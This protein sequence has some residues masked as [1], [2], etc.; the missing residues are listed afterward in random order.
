VRGNLKWIAA[1]ALLAATIGFGP[2]LGWLLMA[3]RPRKV[4]VVDKSVPFQKYR[5]HQNLHWL[6]RAWKV[7]DPS[8]RFLEPERD[9]L[10]FDP[11]ERV[12]RDLR[13]EDLSSADVL[14]VADTYGV[15]RGDYL[16]PGDVAAL[17]RSPKIYGGMT[18]SEA[19]A[20]I[21]FG[22]RGG[23]VVAEFNTFASPTDEA[24]RRRLE[25]FFGLRWTRWVGRYWPNLRDPSEVPSWVGEV[26]E[27]LHQRPF[28]L[29][30]P[31]LVF[32]RDDA[33]MV[34]LQPPH[35][36][37]PS[38]MAMLRTAE[39]DD[40]DGLPERGW[41]RFW[42]DVVEAEG[43]EVVY[44]F[45]V[46]CTPRGRA[47]LQEHGL[48]ARFPA[49]LRHP[50]RSGRHS[51]YLAGDFVDTLTELGDAERWGLLS[52]RRVV[53][54]GTPE[55]RFMWGWYAPLMERIVLHP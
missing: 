47:L 29:T 26:Y 3:P 52:W 42:T 36:L 19:A 7:P 10:G 25:A 53:L 2:R 5:E 50:T 35:H 15:Y 4:V 49:V 9:Y 39:G 21:E 20:L 40:I 48:R 24:T 11:I 34:I 33:D 30:G 38:I 23:L 18:S 37:E 16:R 27:R 12:G 8:G 17:E 32:V 51:W 31:G 14:F 43:A 41:Y 6:L 1:L 13:P 28:D 22:D 54:R 46:Q 55:A 44:E 45:E